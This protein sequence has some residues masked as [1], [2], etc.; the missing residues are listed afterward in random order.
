VRYPLPQLPPEFEVPGVALRQYRDLMLYLDDKSRKRLISDDHVYG[1]TDQGAALFAEHG[2]RRFEVDLNTDKA[3][4]YGAFELTRRKILEVR[5][6]LADE[7]AS[8]GRG[9]HGK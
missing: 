3:V 9:S 5:P 6:D 4:L 2:V 8:L 7:I 1:A